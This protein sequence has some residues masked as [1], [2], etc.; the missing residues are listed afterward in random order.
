MKTQ[1]RFYCFNCRKFPEYVCENLGNYWRCIRYYSDDE[2]EQVNEGHGEPK[3]TCQECDNELYDLDEK[4]ALPED[5]VLKLADV[6]ILLE[7]TFYDYVFSKEDR[8]SGHTVMVIPEK[9]K[10]EVI[11][12]EISFGHYVLGMEPIKYSVSLDWNSELMSLP[13]K[14]ITGYL[15]QKYLDFKLKEKGKEDEQ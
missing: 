2:C 1:T 12:I 13:A 11:E 6:C 8:T 9:I 14:A 4:N 10:K 15:F 7:Q 5:H 3:Y